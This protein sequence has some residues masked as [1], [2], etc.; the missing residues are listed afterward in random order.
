MQYKVTEQNG[1][2]VVYERIDRKILLGA[3]GT[4]AFKQYNNKLINFELLCSR[5]DDECTRMGL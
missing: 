4:E 5:L 1:L 3:V 2:Q